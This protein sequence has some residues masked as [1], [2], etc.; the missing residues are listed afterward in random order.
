MSPMLRA[1]IRMARA[2][3][4]RRCAFFSPTPG[5]SRWTLPPGFLQIPPCLA[6]CLLCENES[7]V[8]VVLMESF[9]LDVLC[10]AP[11]AAYCLIFCVMLCARVKRKGAGGHR[12]TE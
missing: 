8:L 10:N 2:I 4:G 9:K 11:A 1:D 7:V 6:R 12:G 5:S 3:D